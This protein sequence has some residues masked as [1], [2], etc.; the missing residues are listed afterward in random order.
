MSLQSQ[1]PKKTN[2]FYID[3][4]GSINND[5]KVFIHGCIKTDSPIALTT[6]LTELKQ[7]LLDTLYYDDFVT[8]IKGEGFHAT[9]NNMDMRADFYKL[10]PILNY[11]SYFV[12]INKDTE[13]FK[14]LKSEKE[15]HEIFSL[16]L[17][18]LLLDRIE[19]N[20]DDKNIFIFETIQIS[21]KSLENI[22]K[23]LFESIDQTYDCEY[24]IVGKDEENM[25]V[26]DYLNFIFNHI[27]TD[28]KPMK[29]MFQNFEL[30]SPKIAVIYLLNNNLYL[31][32]KKKKHH[33]INIENLLNEFGGKS[34]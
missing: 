32:R 4:S 19:K 5:S 20:K 23:E 28:E 29:R 15:E 3:E 27:L 11:R 10:L 34:G 7:E 16:T 30:V 1:K 13:Y 24:K 2:Y 33:K 22:L 25:G 12:I 6:A 17:K 31:S 26:V 21:K 8:R 14:K 18:K 9:E